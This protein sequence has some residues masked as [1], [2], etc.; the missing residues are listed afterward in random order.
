MKTIIL[1]I[2]LLFLFLLNFSNILHESFTDEYDS[3]FGGLLINRGAII[4]KEFFSNHGPVTYYFAAVIELITKQNFF[5]F[6]VGYQFLIWSSEVLLTYFIWKRYGLREAIYTVFFFAIAAISLEFFWGHL[7]VADN[8]AG[9]LIVGTYIILFY[10][11]IEK[12]ISLKSLSITSLLC[13]LTLF[14]SYTFIFVVFLF[15]IF[16]LVSFFSKNNPYNMRQLLKVTFLIFCPYI[17][18]GLYLLFT[19]SWSDFYFQ[20]VTFNKDYYVYGEAAKAKNIIE[21]AF[22]LLTGNLSKYKDI[23]FSFN[24]FT[25]NNPFVPTLFL[26]N[27][28]LW[29]YLLLT[30][31]IKSLI[32]SIF[33]VLYVNVR[34]EPFKPGE[35]DFHATPYI[36]ISLFNGVYCLTHSWILFNKKVFWINKLAFGFATLILIIY[37]VNFFQFVYD[38]WWYIVN[39]KLNSN[40]PFYQSHPISPFLNPLLEADDYYYIGPYDPESNFYAKGK[41]ASRY[42][43]LFPAMEESSKIYTDFI[44]DI[45]RNKPKIVIYHT[46]YNIF[47]HEPGKDFI[48]HIFENYVT[49]E[50]LKSQK[51][52]EYTPLIKFL[53]FFRYDL[54]RHFFIRKDALDE[55]LEKMALYGYIDNSQS[56]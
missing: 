19:K 28:L 23:L 53:G 12:N 40:E 44:T 17:L 8:L 25:F 45:D 30:R 51:V 50:S 2:I 14:T 31:H 49:L 42:A 22:S 47:G 21:L 43:Y 36:L 10:Y 16:S 41:L 34:N 35:I 3:L 18:F 1:V 32:L 52:Y 39:N 37:L 24:Q 20:T 6:R 48:K 54:E 9:F 38:K 7:L 27:T 11:L 33:V 46:E 4:Y 15:Y 55:I 29:V 56:I 13:F 26:S 5:N